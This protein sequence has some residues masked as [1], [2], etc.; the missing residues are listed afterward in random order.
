M[1]DGARGS[2]RGPKTFAASH[3]AA[4]RYARPDLAAGRAFAR[5]LGLP[6]DSA[7]GQ[8][9]APAAGG[10]AAAGAPAPGTELGQVE[11]PPMIRLVD[12]MLTDSDNVIA[13]ALARQVAL[14][15]KPAG[16]LRRRGDGDRTR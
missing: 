3:G 10:A 4:E 11:S 12:M 13:E 16:L 5:L 2:G 1:T 9:A 8:G 15:R 7:V 6:A 14:A